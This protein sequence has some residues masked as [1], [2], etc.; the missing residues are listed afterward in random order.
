MKKAL[1][2]V[3]LLFGFCLPSVGQIREIADEE[4]SALASSDSVLVVVDGIVSPVRFGNNPVPPHELALQVCPFLSEGDIDTV[5][6]IKAGEMSSTMILCENPGDILLITTHEA[7]AIH[8]YSL[9][10]KHVHK[11]KGIALGSLL[12][13]KR[14]LADIK[15]KWGIKPNRIKMLEIEGKSIRIT[16]K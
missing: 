13:R 10:G 8:D 4:S 6:L 5:R 16:T 2:F 11:R 1:S 12:D 9:D 3:L 7:C 15:K 14:L